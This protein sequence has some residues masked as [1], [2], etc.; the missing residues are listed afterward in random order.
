MK[1]VKLGE[2]LYEVRFPWWK[3]GSNRRELCSAILE[4]QAKGK[5]ITYLRYYTRPQGDIAFICTTDK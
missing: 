4:L 3:L 1:V 2:D 5:I